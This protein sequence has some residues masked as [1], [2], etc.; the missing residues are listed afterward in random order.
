MDCF[1]IGPTDDTHQKWVMCVM[2]CEMHMCGNSLGDWP[3]EIRALFHH[4]ALET[5]WIKLCKILMWKMYYRG[6]KFIVSWTFC[7]FRWEILLNRKCVIR[8]KCVLIIQENFG[9][10]LFLGVTQENIIHSIVFNEFHC[11]W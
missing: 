1:F 3:I 4:R 2:S 11:N 10:K 8:V 5:N 6:E 9:T 7:A